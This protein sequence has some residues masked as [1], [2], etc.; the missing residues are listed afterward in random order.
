[1]APPANGH[2]TV[3]QSTSASSPPS[4]LW[5]L[6]Q[7]SRAGPSPTD[8]GISLAAPSDAAFAQTDSPI[9]F[10]E[11]P[12]LMTESGSGGQESER[13]TMRPT[14]SKNGR[15][16]AAQGPKDAQPTLE[17]IPQEM[18][19]SGLSL[20]D[21][22]FTNL[23][24]ARVP[25]PPLTVFDARKGRLWFWIKVRCR[26][27]CASRLK[28]DGVVHLSI[29]WLSETPAGS[30]V[31]DVFPVTIHGTEWRTWMSKSNLSPGRWRVTVHD[32]ATPLCLAD[33][34]KIC[35]FMIQVE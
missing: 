19:A 4:L 22:A 9:E 35:E 28:K 2:E 23:V 34:P 32:G 20:V 25:G 29:R 1:M 31:R 11:I 5:A 15:A 12:P 8:S 7:E 33:Q 26:D 27:T 16:A 6:N 21:A 3:Q 10:Q 18:A 13:E 30:Q 24:A 14:S 17:P